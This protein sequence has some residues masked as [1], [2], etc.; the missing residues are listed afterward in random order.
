MSTILKPEKEETL[1]KDKKRAEQ[2][3]TAYAELK[4]DFDSLRLKEA[5]ELA[6]IMETYAEAMNPIKESMKAAEEELSEIGLRNKKQFNEKN[7]W[8]FE[9]GYLLLSKKTIVKKLEGFEWKKFV[10]KWPQFV[11]MEF[12]IKPLK[13][14]FTD[15]DT[16]PKV[17]KYNIDLDTKES[18]EVKI[19]DKV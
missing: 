4:K 2:L 9:V 13:E 11:S 7:R 16:R 1:K 5:A 10:G 18:I 14:A 8:G 3:L 15:G 19:E 12:N 17:M 6:P